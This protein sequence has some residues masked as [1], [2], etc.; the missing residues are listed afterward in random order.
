[1][2]SATAPMMSAGVIAANIAWKSAKVA[3]EMRG[4]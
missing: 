1:M 4:S 2:R 3:A